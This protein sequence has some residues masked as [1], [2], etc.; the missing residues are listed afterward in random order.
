[1]DAKTCV[2]EVIALAGVKMVRWPK[3]WDNEEEGKKSKMKA[4]SLKKKKKVKEMRRASRR[5]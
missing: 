2:A 3:T 5:G 4:A 1:M